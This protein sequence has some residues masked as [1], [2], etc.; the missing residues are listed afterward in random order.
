MSRLPLQLPILTR[1]AT[2][3]PLPQTLLCA[4]VEIT[5]SSLLLCVISRATDSREELHWRDALLTEGLPV[6]RRGSPLCGTG[7]DG[8]GTGGRVLVAPDVGRR[9]LVAWRDGTSCLCR[10]GIHGM[11]CPAV[12]ARYTRRVVRLSCH[13]GQL[14]RVLASEVKTDY[15]WIGYQLDAER[16]PTFWL[17]IHVRFQIRDHFWIPHQKPKLIIRDFSN[18]ETVVKI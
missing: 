12:D 17:C 3:H 6:A 18:Q 13:T 8:G 14:R 9:A 2:H 5:C 15:S 11:G 7:R 10:V 1:P 16:R 4:T